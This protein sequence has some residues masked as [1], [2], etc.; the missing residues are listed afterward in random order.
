MASG[1]RIGKLGLVNYRDHPTQQNYKVFNFMSKEEAD[2][3]ESILLREKV[4]YEKDSDEVN[5]G[6]TYLFGVKADSFARAQRAN[7]EVSAKFRN[8][9]I[10]NTALRLFLLIFFFSF[11]ILAIIGYVKS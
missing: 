5:S 7:F 11:L 3:F 2:M 9:L 1:T 4:W 6:T 8:P 10:K